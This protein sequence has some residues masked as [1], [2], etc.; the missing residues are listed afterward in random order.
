MEKIGENRI[1]IVGDLFPVPSNFSKFAAGD[2]SYLFG[3]KISELFAKADY[4][5]CN[6]EGAL[7][8]QPGV[9]E[10]TGPSVYAPQ[11]V[12]NGFVKFGIN[13]CTLANNHITDAGD[14]GVLDTMDVLDKAGI[15][16]LGAG[17]NAN[18]I[19]HFVSFLV[20]G[21]KIG[22]Y[23][24]AET[25]YNEPSNEK[26]GAFL[27]DEYV[28]CQELKEYKAQCDYIIVI[29]HGGS[30]KYRY[31][32]PQTKKRFH[33]MVDCGADMILSQHTHCVGSEE[34]Y[35]GAYL[36]YG[37][38]NF[39]FRSFNNEF[40]DTGLIVELVISDK[41]FSV[42]KHLVD[43]VKDTVRYD[44]KQDFTAF[45]E[46]SA[47]ISDEQLLEKKFG[48][49]CLNEL[50]VYLK[51]YKGKYMGYRILRRF[52][53]KQYRRI[54][55]EAYERDQMLFTLHS[56]RSEQNREIAIEGIK[57]YLKRLGK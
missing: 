27:Y 18:S 44:D 16:H 2:V 49:Y 7:T 22:L 40:T 39:L 51:A 38:G 24:V 47:C 50:P 46:R 13:C 4:R 57:Q 28:V 36:L 19:C 37:Q 52:F 31:P 12:V 26:P 11:S 54:N 25:M 43:A 21:K 15:K 41:G 35:K 48:Y 6:L 53:P 17:I 42:K 34:Y 5:I 45:N 8:D 55:M 1:I 10:K 14:Q 3:D 29:Y 33:R 20:G 32:S 56:L 9:C 30:E 23:N